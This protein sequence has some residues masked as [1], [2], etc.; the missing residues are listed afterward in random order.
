M[1]ASLAK[2][3]V[4]HRTHKTVNPQLL[5]EVM[6][7]QHTAGGINAQK[8]QLEQVSIKQDGGGVFGAKGETFSLCFCHF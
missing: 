8:V 6:R 5:T 3:G 4:P 1:L 7:V 2:P